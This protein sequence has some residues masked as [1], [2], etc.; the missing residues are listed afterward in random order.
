MSLSRE[1]VAFWH[2]PEPELNLAAARV[3]FAGQ[4]LWVLASRDLAALAAL[5]APFW[6]TVPEAV[7]WRYLLLPA[8]SSM[9]PSLQML[10]FA[11]LVAFAAGLRPRLTGVLA[12][13]LLYHLAPLETLL[14]TPSPYERGLTIAIPALLALSFAG[15]AGWG[16]RLAR[17]FL[18]QVYFF[19]GWSKLVR[20]GFEWISAGN[21][22]QWLLLFNEQDQLVVFRRL[23]PWLAE[24][25]GLCLAIGALTV[26]VELTFPLAVF[27]PRTRPLLVGAVAT[28]HVGIFFGMNI[29]FLNLPQLLVFVDWERVRRRLRPGHAP[30]ASAPY[31]K[32]PAQ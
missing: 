32:P 28:M 24:R 4:A 12:G 11:M 30:A 21:L 5:P 8:L 1:W 25:P 14:W 22:R 15:K 27:V 31:T 29:V 26:A 20:V 19:A 9:A 23:G 16:L 6:D 18:A 2:G 10:A 17:L 3:I 13:L 7:R